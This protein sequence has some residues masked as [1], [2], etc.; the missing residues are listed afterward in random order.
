MNENVTLKEDAIINR[1]YLIRGMKVMLDR[2]LAELYDVETKYL[3]RQVK[4]NTD[5]F[6][7]DF[8]FE[9]N[10]EEF[11][12]WR[13]QFVT[14]NAEKMGLRYAPF[15]FTEQGIAMLSSVLNSKKAIQVN[16]QIIRIFTKMRVF[17]SNQT[18]LQLKMEQ[19][20]K[21]L[22]SQNNLNNKF[23]QDIET[24]FHALKQ[25]LKKDPEPRKRIGFK[26][27]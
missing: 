16:I 2:D 22:L 1:I 24:I 3:K 12:N 20:E 13:S 11:E 25:L 6:P 19:F 4:R 26:P 8:M 17:L 5:R 15:C 7:D 14:S 10:K 23:D 21:A 18:E 9:M 27:D